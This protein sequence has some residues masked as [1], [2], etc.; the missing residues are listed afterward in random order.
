MFA[1][2][3][4]GA[5]KAGA[6]MFGQI[7]RLEHRPFFVVKGHG[8]GMYPGAKTSGCG[9]CIILGRIVFCAAFAEMGRGKGF[10]KGCGAAIGTCQN[11]AFQL[12]G[13]IIMASKPAFKTMSV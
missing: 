4:H 3:A 5:I 7:P 13:E 10:A 12:T 1:D 9:A 11:P 2:A 6:H 8:R